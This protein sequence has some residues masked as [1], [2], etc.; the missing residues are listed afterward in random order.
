L[1]Y[2]TNTALTH[3]VFTYPPPDFRLRPRLWRVERAITVSP[4]APKP[5]STRR[6]LFGAA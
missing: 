1:R 3:Q 6:R 2:G 4:L 5:E